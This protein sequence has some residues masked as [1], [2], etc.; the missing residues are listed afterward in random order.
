MLAPEHFILHGCNAQG[1]MGKGVAKLIRDRYPSAFDDYFHAYETR[2]L[3]LGDV[4]WAQTDNHV[5]LNAIT[6]KFYRK[7]DEPPGVVYVDYEHGIRRCM[8]SI[9][10]NFIDNPINDAAVAMPLIGAGLAGGHWPTIAA[11]IEQEATA[12][13]PVVYLLD[14]VVPS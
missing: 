4:I 8:V 11:I 14:G 10:Q 2:G 5:V 7:H 6:Q 1:K 12:F 3:S 13:R 9:N